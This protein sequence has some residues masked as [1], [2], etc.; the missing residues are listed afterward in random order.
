MKFIIAFLV[1]FFCEFAFAD[2]KTGTDAGATYDTAL[3]IRATALEEAPG[4]KIVVTSAELGKEDRVDVFRVKPALKAKTFIRVK[5]KAEHSLSAEVLSTDGKVLWSKSAKDGVFSGGLT[6][7]AY[8]RFSTE[9]D[10]PQNKYV[11]VVWMAPKK[12]NFIDK[13]VKMPVGYGKEPPEG[14]DP[15]VSPKAVES[16]GGNLYWLIGAVALLLVVAVCRRR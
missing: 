14:F 7:D 2:A 4:G 9:E 5:F 3:R 8:L 12:A 6:A 10:S 13:M 15:F 16:T 11:F 1:L